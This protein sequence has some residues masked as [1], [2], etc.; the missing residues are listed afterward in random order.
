MFDE[1]GYTA[2]YE[3]NEVY[4][5]GINTSIPAYQ[6]AANPSNPLFKPVAELGNQDL[7]G[8]AIEAGKQIPGGVPT[9]RWWDGAV[10]Y[11][12]NNVQ[13]MLDQE[14][15]PQ[16]VLEQST[17]DIQTNLIDRQ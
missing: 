5:G 12:G 14:L 7:W 11:L 13:K 8:I 17:K 1:A 9:P 4:P 6:P 15:S 3:P 16:E 2:V 10:E